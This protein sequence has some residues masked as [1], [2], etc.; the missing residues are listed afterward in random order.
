MALRCWPRAER[1]RAQPGLITLITSPE[2]V[3]RTCRRTTPG[4]DGAN[5][6]RK[7]LELPQT[8]TALL[9]GPGLAAEEVPEF[10]RAYIRANSAAKPFGHDCGRQCA[11]LVAPGALHQKTA[12][13]LITPHPGE[14][15]RS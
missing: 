9:V 6:G 7:H 1:K 8:C 12:L 13:R 11:E 15:A 2:L 4:R 14:A 3:L 10:L 5:L